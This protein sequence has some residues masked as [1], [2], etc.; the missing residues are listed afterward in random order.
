MKLR[1]ISSILTLTGAMMMAPYIYAQETDTTAAPA[2]EEKAGKDKRPVKNVFENNWLINSQTVVVPT[3]NSLQFDIN[4][5]FGDLANGSKDMWGLYAPSNIRLGLSYT[6]ISNLQ[7]GA[8]MTKEAMMFDFNLKYSV[9]KQTRSG[10]FPVFITYYGNAVIEGGAND[11]IWKLPFQDAT[12]GDSVVY[13]E[14]PEYT[15]RMSF[16]NSIIIG[17]KI[18]D[19]FSIQAAFSYVHKNLIDT[20]GVKDFTHDNMAISGLGR[21]KF[22]GDMSLILEYFYPLTPANYQKTVGTTIIDNKIKPSFAIGFEAT[23]SAHAF[24]LFITPFSSIINQRD[25]MYN[26]SDP[27][28]ISDYRLGFNVTRIWNF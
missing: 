9:L 6:P 19:M 3:A 17:R 23:T 2:T 5:R 16:Y 8:G 7:V 4:H 27:K 26:T 15:D 10:S 14:F 25:I 28:F 12:K 20:M 1:K 13:K 18:N 22:Y 24:Q 21:V 11:T